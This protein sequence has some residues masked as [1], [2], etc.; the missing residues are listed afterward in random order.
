MPCSTRKAR[1]LLKEQKKATIV[2]Y[3]PFTIQLSY[4]TGETTQETKLGI[5]LGAKHMGA[6]VTSDEKVLGKSRN[7]ATSRCKKKQ[8][9]NKENL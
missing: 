1:I 9:G 7:R 6:A 5:D 3:N 2:R 4:P 8:P